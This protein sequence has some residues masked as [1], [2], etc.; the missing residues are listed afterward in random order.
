MG[1]VGDFNECRD[2][3]EAEK[4][5]QYVGC[6][7]TEAGRP[8]QNAMC[9]TK[10]ECEGLTVDVYD[11]VSNSTKPEASIWG[12][13]KPA[14]CVS[15]YD[16]CYSPPKKTLLNVKIG[17]TATTLDIGA[18]LNVLYTYALGIAGV[19]AVVMIMVGGVQYILGS[20]S[21]SESISKGKERIRNAIVGLVL[22]LAAYLVLATVNPN[23]VEFKTLRLPKPKPSLFLGASCEVYEEELQFEVERVDDSKPAECGAIGTLTHDSDGNKILEETTCTYEL[24]T[25]TDDRCVHVAAGYECMSCADYPDDFQPSA[26]ACGALS[27]LGNSVGDRRRCVF[28][29][30]TTAGTLIGND[31]YCAIV[32]P[33]CGSIDSCEDYGTYTF[34]EIRGVS[35]VNLNASTTIGYISDETFTDV[36]TNNPCG[37]FANGNGCVY[38]EASGTGGC[39][40]AP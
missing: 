40:A 28:Q 16:Y 5:T 27:P 18:Y 37:V 22:L 29:E 25:G 2:V 34:I 11:P 36:C 32:D 9:W 39:V 13:T 1:A 7:T 19:I 10:E 15:P 6:A 14:Q 20:A 3:C 31:G 4:L 24:C 23:L 17:N 12:D 26:S 33:H 38:S 30:P 35:A 21:G 8:E